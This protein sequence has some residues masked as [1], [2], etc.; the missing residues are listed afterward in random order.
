MKEVTKAEVEYVDE[1]KEFICFL[2]IKGIL[3]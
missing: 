1:L 3:V 2:I